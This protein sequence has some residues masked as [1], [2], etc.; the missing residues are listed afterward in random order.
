MTPSRSV[1]VQRA[2][3]FGVA[4]PSLP[5]SAT[6]FRH[7]FRS[8]LPSQS[9]IKSVQSF[10][11]F[12]CVCGVCVCVCGPLSLYFWKCIALSQSVCMCVSCCNKHLWRTSGTDSDNNAQAQSLHV[13]TEVTVEVLFAYVCTCL[14]FSFFF[15]LF[16]TAQVLSKV[17]DCRLNSL[18]FKLFLVRF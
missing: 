5:D 4:F 14:S 3:R 2:F 1:L 17:H 15:L 6:E 13:L 16:F 12:L 7:T 18:V 11:G 9:S 10:A 8:V